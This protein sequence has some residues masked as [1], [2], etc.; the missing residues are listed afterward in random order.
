MIH[1][2]EWT[3]LLGINVCKMRGIFFFT[4]VRKNSTF[5]S[6]LWNLNEWPKTILLFVTRSRLDE[7]DNRNAPRFEPE[8]HRERSRNSRFFGQED[9]Y[10]LEDEVER[11]RARPPP[12][13]RRLLLS[14]VNSHRLVYSC[15]YSVLGRKDHFSFRLLIQTVLQPCLWSVFDWNPI[16]LY[17]LVLIWSKFIMPLLT[18]CRSSSKNLDVKPSV[19]RAMW[20]SP[21]SLVFFVLIVTSNLNF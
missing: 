12:D 10:G 4:Y 14:N 2:V 9:D 21:S 3:F 1:L 6:H 19:I 7:I 20:G 18:I 13:M 17:C 5:Q 8:R 11:E 15:M 16:G